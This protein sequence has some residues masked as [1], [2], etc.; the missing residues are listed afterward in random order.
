M[1]EPWQIRVYDRQQLVHAGEC[2][3]PVELGRQGEGEPGPF[4]QRQEAGRCRVVIA[5]SD[6]D[7]I[8]RRHALLEPL[9]E[10]RVR[11]TNLS[12]TM[13]IR[14]ADGG[15][16]RPGACAEAPSPVLLTLGKKAV[17]L[18][19]AEPA[20]LQLLGLPDATRPPGYVPPSSALA[21]L[22]L[23]AAVDR[24][25]LLRWLHTTMGVLQSAA[26]SP[27]FFAR[28]ARA[29]VDIVGLDSGMVLLW[30]KGEWRTEVLAQGAQAAGQPH[31]PPSRHVL[32]K[33]AHEKRTLWQVP[34]PA[35][36][37]ASS[38]AGVRAVVAAPIL[39]RDG[40]VIGALYGDRRQDGAVGTAAP[41][42]N[43]EAMLVELIAGGVAAGL[44]RVEQER[45]A[46]AA[47]IRLEQSFTP[48]VARHLAANP[49]LLKGRDSEVTV[50]FA[51]IRSFSRLSQRLEPA[52]TVEWVRDV[53]GALSECVLA[54]EGVLV[55]YIGD[56]LMA[57]WGAPDE[58]PEHAR[59]ACRA[60][61]AM[62]EQLPGLNGRWQPVLGEPMGLGIGIDTGTARV[63]DIGSRY[64]LK[65]GPLGNTPNFASRVQ[66]ATKFLKTS[67]L[68]TGATQ[69]RLGPGFETRRLGRVR[70]VNIGEP[71]ALYELAAPGRPR[72][73]AFRGEYE[74]A[75]AEF[76][77]GNFRAA[78]GLLG[79]LVARHPDD[80]PSL[81][82]MSRAVSAV[83]EG[84]AE[85]D[86]VWDLPGK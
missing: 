53:M 85:A 26:G 75:L 43:L 24:E 31:V 63:G 86:P 68:I 66:G 45:A 22:P 69:A 6:E 81:V 51:D 70:L 30:D 19:K 3:L 64:K 56:E 1:A 12:A 42:T 49:D 79:P 57:M 25:A 39:D 32:T 52:V 23:P 28:G 46:V 5:R 13:P 72:W 62:L 10:G 47:T 82:L 18:Q 60:A 4:N 33:V 27:D 55:D 16:V 67:L 2:A 36:Q 35:A 83:M 76:E 20:P 50:L 61:L 37:D 7:A 84:D 65:Y 21:T 71:L 74:A 15:E 73:T 11:L 38:L 80:G 34:R 29:I 17:R 8:S 54:H 48:K 14:L 59:L 41:L 58:Q 78:A 44:A 9:A 77:R 40:G